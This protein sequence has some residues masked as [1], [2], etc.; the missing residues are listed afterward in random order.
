MFRRLITRKSTLITIT[1]GLGVLSSAIMPAAANAFGW[2]GGH[3]H[4]GGG[5]AGMHRPHPGPWGGGYGHR[6]YPGGWGRGPYRFPPVIVERPIYER[7]APVMMA[8]P[9]GPPQ[10]AAP[11]PCTCLTKQYQD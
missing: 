1:L 9:S 4:G 3:S 11:A 8:A 5:Y 7:P 2:G 6:P 10:A